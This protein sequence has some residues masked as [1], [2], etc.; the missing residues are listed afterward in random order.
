VESQVENI[1]NSANA[2]LSG[3]VTLSQDINKEEKYVTVVVGVKEDTIN[4]ASTI[5]GQIKTGLVNAEQYKSSASK[6][7]TH[8]NNKAKGREIRRS[9]MYD[10]F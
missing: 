2:I 3:I 10:A 7:L 4:A 1:Q 6:Q 9:S 5:S 8:L